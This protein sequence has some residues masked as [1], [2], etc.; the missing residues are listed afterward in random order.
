[1]SFAIPD[2][3]LLHLVQ[4]DAPYGDIT[5]SGLGIAEQ[6]GRATFTAASD[7]T[8]ACVED[9]A[10]MLDLC[11]CRSML[12]T[13]GGTFV[14]RGTLLLEATGRAGDLH[15]GAKTA[16][17]LMELASG[18]ATRAAAIVAAA[19]SANPLISVACTRKHMPG[20]K[21]IALKA[22]MAGGAVPHRLGLSDSVLVFADHRVFLADGAELADAFR[23]LR[24]HTPER[25]LGAEAESEDEALMLAA[26]GADVVQIDKATPETVA[27][28]AA[29]FRARVPRPLLAAA[30][31]INETNAATFAAAGA[32]LLVT[33]APYYAAPCDVKLRMSPCD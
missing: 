33:S 13:H 2:Q 20:A 27:R 29:T 28:L 18:I 24:A 32:D 31:G 3:D 11:G 22:I 6:I 14:P 30:G 1:M 10:R 12:H 16:Q 23:Q 15:R 17:V 19:R 9:A 4:E 21:R 8:V 7:M 25:R 26:V 5:T